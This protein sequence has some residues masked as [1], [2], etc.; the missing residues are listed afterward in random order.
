MVQGSWLKYLK[1]NERSV[2]VIFQTWVHPLVCRVQVSLI[3]KDSSSGVWIFPKTFQKISSTL[4]ITDTKIF[5]L[6]TGVRP[7]VLFLTVGLLWLST[8]YPYI[9]RRIFRWKTSKKRMEWCYSEARIWKQ[10][11]SVLSSSSPRYKDFISSYSQPLPGMWPTL[12]YHLLFS[13]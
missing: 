11:L 7:V 2:M 13:H 10:F 1:L 12:V 4:T 3:R 6:A 9:H 5:H 8:H